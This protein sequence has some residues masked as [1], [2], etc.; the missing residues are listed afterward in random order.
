MSIQFGVQLIGGLYL[1]LGVIGLLPIESINTL[2]HG[3]VDTPYVL[4]LFA[5]NTFHNLIHV[6]IGATAL[7]AARTYNGARLWGRIGGGIL[8]VL[9]LIGA[10]QTVAE[11]FPHDQLLLG[12]VSLNA[13]MHIL[14]VVTSTVGLYLGFRTPPEGMAENAAQPSR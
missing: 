4:N 12:M 9:F 10:V 8:F 14:H 3:G 13:P 1:L 6:F 7:F 11:G 5:G 2:H